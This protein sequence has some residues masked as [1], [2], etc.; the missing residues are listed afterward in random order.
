MKPLLMNEFF[1]VH[2]EA[3]SPYWIAY[4]G[5]DTKIPVL[6]TIPDIEKGKILY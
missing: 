6:D 4:Q 2:L 1:Y 5:R 3:K